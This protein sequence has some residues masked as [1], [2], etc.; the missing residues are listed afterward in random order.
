MSQ[1]HLA[2]RS[3]PFIM[4]LLCM[5]S[6]GQVRNELDRRRLNALIHECRPGR[7]DGLKAFIESIEHYRMRV[8]A[9]RVIAQSSNETAKNW[10]GTPLLKELYKAKEDRSFQQ[11]A[12]SFLPIED[13]LFEEDIVEF[14]ASFPNDIAEKWTLD[15]YRKWQ[16]AG[17][18]GRKRYEAL[19]IAHKWDGWFEVL[20]SKTNPDASVEELSHYW[21]E[22]RTRPPLD[23][24]EI[25]RYAALLRKLLD[26]GREMPHVKH[27]VKQRAVVAA[28]HRYPLLRSEMALASLDE[29]SPL[30]ERV[31]FAKQWL[32]KYGDDVEMLIGMKGIGDFFDN[33][34]EYTPTQCAA[35]FKAWFGSGFF[36]HSVSFKRLPKRYPES[37]EIRAAVYREVE[38]WWLENKSKT[39]KEMKS[40][41]RAKTGELRQRLFDAH[42]EI[43]ARR[44]RETDEAEWVWM[45]ATRDFLQF[46][47]KTKPRGAR[48][49]CAVGAYQAYHEY[50]EMEKG[51]T[52]EK[53]KLAK[54]R[55]RI[56]KP[57]LDE[58][59]FKN[60]L[61]RGEVVN[62]EIPTVTNEDI[63]KAR[64]RALRPL[65]TDEELEVDHGVNTVP[66]HSSDHHPDADTA[67]SAKGSE[68]DALLMPVVKWG[69]AIIAI[70]C[71]LSLLLIY[72]RRS[73][74]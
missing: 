7:L 48:M 39:L 12:F 53:I 16:I 22:L 30:D 3:I 40:S 61:D 33:I 6:M 24:D 56:L 42:L 27:T 2:M 73:A 26:D 34:R 49:G 9:L 57:A 38:Q 64:L 18:P 74:T 31:A 19:I 65:A 28:K 60:P 32:D 41:A 72:K 67:S 54:E 50:L 44:F 70:L 8:E 63:R 58:F 36:M 20:Q 21:S 52:P 11:I 23:K 35:A 25:I 45:E 55:I 29:R 46:Q 71:A 68:S 51:T 5:P 62:K 17:R 14:V 13:P 47:V 15:A 10:I 4:L 59:G 37:N 66:A 1:R 69:G 43:M